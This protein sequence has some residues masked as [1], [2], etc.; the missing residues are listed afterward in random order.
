MI[1]L[2]GTKIKSSSNSR[3]RTA[4]AKQTKNLNRNGRHRH[5]TSAAN[6]AVVLSCCCLPSGDLFST[7]QPPMFWGR[8]SQHVW[9]VS[10]CSSTCVPS[11]E[12]A[13]GL[14][15]T[16]TAAQWIHTPCGHP[17][18]QKF[19]RWLTRATCTAV[20][21]RKMKYDKERAFRDGWRKITSTNN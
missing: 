8:Q 10:M 14:T 2:S 12:S 1:H 19:P 9:K 5:R 21:K 18:R 13:I 16:R 7:I 20:S 11:R 17:A 3:K 15:W 4:T 6:G